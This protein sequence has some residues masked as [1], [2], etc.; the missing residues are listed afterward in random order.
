MKIRIVSPFPEGF[1]CG[2]NTTAYRW[3]R[4][5]V[6]LGHEVA[7]TDLEHD[8]AAD[9]LIALGAVKC[10]GLILRSYRESPTLPVCVALTGSDLADIG[11]SAAAQS[12]T[13]L[14]TKVIVFQPAALDL[15]SKAARRNAEVI[16]QAAQPSRSRPLPRRDCF[17]VTL[18]ANLR[19]EKNPL[20]AARAARLLR[21]ESKVRI[22]HFGAVLDEA[23]ADEARAEMTV[24]GRYHWMGAAAPASL[25]KRLAASQALI[26]PSDVEAG[27]NVVSE[28]IVDG[29]PIL[30]SRIPG[31]TGVLGDR[32]SGY[33]TPGDA[34][35]L[36]Q[37]L[38]EL[39]TSPAFVRRLRATSDAVAKTLRPSGEKRCWRR[40]LSD[41]AA[42][43]E[44]PSARAKG[45]S[46]S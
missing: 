17:V 36:A 20:L 37:L 24:N 46:G 1:P 6:S 35:E 25:R 4:L 2:S 10:A 27:A 38:H 16:L 44:K 39:E 12:A 30:A 34:A 14:A 33:F 29:I 5:F 3:A 19:V 21:P 41:I 26:V 18:A 22:E 11:K 45:S 15:L 8:C 43:M 42:T 32:Y 31:N 7:V 28:A 13:G 23:M 40:V 9:L